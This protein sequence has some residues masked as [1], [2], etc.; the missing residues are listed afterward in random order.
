MAGLPPGRWHG[1][2]ELGLTEAA[3]VSERQ[4]ELLFGQGR[5]RTPTASSAASWTTAP[6]RPRHGWLRT[7]AA[8]EEIAALKQTPLL[9]LDFTV[10]PQASR[11]AL[12]A[13]GEQRDWG[14]RIRWSGIARGR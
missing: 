6:T 7:R 9:A 1:L 8:V 10:R 4:M 13:A 12:V 2:D 5:H 3:E 14:G 11:I